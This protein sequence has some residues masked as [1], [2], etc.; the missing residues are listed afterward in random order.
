MKARALGIGALV[1]VLGGA[2]AWA[3]D[4]GPVADG[5]TISGEVK[6]QGAPPAAKPL[7]ITKDKDVCGVTP[8]TEEALVV[9][10]GGG[11]K[12]AVVSIA[13]ISKGKALDATKPVLDQKGCQYSPHVL[14]VPAGVS[15]DITNNDGILHNI[16]TYSKKNPPLNLAQPKFKKV[17]QQK[18]DQPEIFE[19][20]CDAHGWMNGWFVI[21][22]HPYYAVT[23]DSGAF[24]LTDVP[25]GE[26][27]LKVWHEKLGEKTQKVTVAAKG[28]AKAS[29]ELAG[30]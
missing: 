27:E 8:K 1:V 11:L 15:V 9:G 14:L 29:F 5:G 3:Y 7:D 30:K 12:N 17:M 24:K 21:Q 2:P 22:D 13:S 10:K 20:R 23:D 4:A 25:A 6:F 26:Y 16:H 28:E 19:V 18:F